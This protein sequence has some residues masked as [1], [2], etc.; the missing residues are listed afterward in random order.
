M[1]PALQTSIEDRDSRMAEQLQKVEGS[2]ASSVERS[3]RVFVGDHVLSV[4]PVDS[5]VLQLCTEDVD[6]ILHA[7]GVTGSQ[8]SEESVDIC[9]SGDVSC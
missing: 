5:R 3:Q 4:R 1:D 2:A 9:C 8:V 7:A 6:E